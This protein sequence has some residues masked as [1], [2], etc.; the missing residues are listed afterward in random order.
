MKQVVFSLLGSFV[1][2]AIGAYMG[3]RLAT[4]CPVWP[5]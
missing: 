5:W 3:W 2:S 1:G 4:G